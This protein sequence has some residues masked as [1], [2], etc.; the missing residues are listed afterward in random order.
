MK[1]HKGKA[2]TFQNQRTFSPNVN[3]D[4]DYFLSGILRIKK[5][6]DLGHYLG[7]PSFFS[8][9]KSNDLQP[10]VDRVW[11]VVQGWK[12]SFLSIARKEVLNKSV[13]QA[14]PMSFFQLPQKLCD[15]ITRLFARFWWGSQR[16]KGKVRWKNW[17]FL[18]WPKAI[19]GMNFRDLKGFNQA[20]AGKQVWRLLSK[21]DSWVAGVLKS[22]YFPN[23][24][25]L[26]A[27][28]INSSFL[29]KNFLWGRDLFHLGLRYRIENGNTIRVFQ[30]PWLPRCSTFKPIGGCPDDKQT[31]AM[32]SIDPNGNWVKS[33]LEESFCSEDV[34]IIRWLPTNP[35]LQDKWI[36]LFNNKGIYLV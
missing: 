8:K 17:E 28:G 7:L 16:R 21:P 36:W 4:H 5:L 27:E 26:E 29:W 18:C 25:L 14:L 33:K 3:D 6:N 15:E 12:N 2:L 10:I 19:G 9:N 22:I 31:R 13:G 1:M 35:R 20:L 11:K 24:S 34:E 32:D 23:S 30:D